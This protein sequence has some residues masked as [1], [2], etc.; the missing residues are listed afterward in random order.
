MHYGVDAICTFVLMI[1]K[2]FSILKRTLIYTVGFFL[3]LTLALLVFRK[4]I[5]RYAIQQL[6]PYF[7]VPVYIHDVDFTFWQTFPNFSLRLSGVLIH[8]FDEETGR[9]TDTLLYA[10][11]I[12]LKAN[13]WSIL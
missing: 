12:D 8:D 13:T 3:L 5:E 7:K 10:K 6:D 1:K 4:K 9:N 11:T 2:L